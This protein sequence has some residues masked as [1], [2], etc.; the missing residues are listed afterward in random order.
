[1]CKSHQQPTI[2]NFYQTLPVIFDYILVP[3]DENFWAISG[4]YI[5]FELF[6][7]E[8][9]LDFG[10]NSLLYTSEWWQLQSMLCGLFTG[11]ASSANIGEISDR[12]SSL[13]ACLDL[14]TVAHLQW[15]IASIVI[16]TRVLLCCS[17]Q[18]TCLILTGRLKF[19]TTSRFWNAWVCRLALRKANAPVEIWRRLQKW[20]QSH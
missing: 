13:S 16:C 15:T 7:I 6:T 4:F 1:M 9:I 19:M 10:D 14:T 11:Q 5:A 17:G 3:F 2:L 20:Y 12:L 8:C 18:S